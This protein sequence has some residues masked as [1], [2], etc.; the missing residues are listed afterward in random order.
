LPWTVPPLHA[1][2]IA[3]M[4]LAGLLAMAWSL[5]DGAWR[6]FASRSPWPACGPAR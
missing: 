2:F 6:R 3:A 5:A 4:Y 1:R